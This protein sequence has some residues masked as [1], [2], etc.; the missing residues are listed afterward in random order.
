M[1]LLQNKDNKL[2]LGIIIAVFLIL[3]FQHCSVKNSVNN[4]TKKLE[5]K[6]DSLL[7]YTN[8]KNDSILESVEEINENLEEQFLQQLIYEE[9]I[10]RKELSIGQLK[11]LLQKEKQNNDE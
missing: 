11:V 1:N 6:I 10:D 4:T 7:I 5:Y 9:A 8:E 3:S 2:I